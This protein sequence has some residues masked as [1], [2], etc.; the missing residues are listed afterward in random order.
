MDCG[1]KKI[2]S[3]QRERQKKVLHTKENY[4]R[5]GT[6]KNKNISFKAI[7]LNSS[8]IFLTRKK[9]HFISKKYKEI[10]MYQFLNL[11][12]LLR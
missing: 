5:K 7:D 2:S 4:I 1:I 10:Y 12:P 6:K 11:K 3:N 8:H 9:K